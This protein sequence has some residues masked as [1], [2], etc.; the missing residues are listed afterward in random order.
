MTNSNNETRELTVDEL[1][2]V[3]GGMPVL[4][5]IAI[6]IGT[7]IAANAIYDAVKDAH[8]ITDFLNYARNH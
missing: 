4:A 6:G 1:G 8:G 7:S 2:A 5:A 3:S